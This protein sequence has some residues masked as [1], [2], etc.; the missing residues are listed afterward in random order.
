MPVD[1][2]PHLDRFNGYQRACREFR[3]VIPD[4]FNIADAILSRHLD[5]ATRVALLEM[6]PGGLNT[7]TYGGLDYLS[8]KFA[9]ALRQQGVSQGDSVAV[10]LS[11]SAPAII[12]QLG[13]LKLGA[14]VVPLSPTLETS[15]LDFALRDSGARALIAH[16]TDRDKLAST[17]SSAAVVLVVNT[18]T[19]EFGDTAPD[20][21]FWREVFEASADFAFVETPANSPAF[22][23]YSPNSQAGFGRAT[24]N[25]ASLIYQLP[26]F[27]MSNNFQLGDDT[28]FWTGQD[29]TSIDSS[30][31]SVYPALW[32]GWRLLADKSP[33]T[34]LNAWGLIERCEVTN[35]FV[36]PSELSQLRES[37]PPTASSGVLKLRRIVIAGAVGADLYDWASRTLGASVGTVYC[38]PE[39]GS[40]AASCDAWFEARPGSVGRAVPGYSITIIDEHGREL[41]SHRKGQVAIRLTAPPGSGE[42][43]AGR[44]HPAS[45]AAADLLITGD[46]GVKDE[47][48]YVWLRS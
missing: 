33:A 29:W 12:A 32:Y 43:L 25:H 2:S 35:L 7:Y 38:N 30:L 40:V 46:V 23:F 45:H 27:S 15:A 28:T 4:R 20:L 34:D 47:N 17:V 1:P 21:D 18:L 44:P 13:A 42:R 22:M 3:C 10:I 41:P 5:A 26:P 14:V 39:V 19:P 36:N 16:H 31:C 48:G 8:D 37:S 24:H 11:Q 9:T 6:R